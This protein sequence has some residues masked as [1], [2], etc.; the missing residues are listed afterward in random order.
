MKA[1]PNNPQ[2]PPVKHHPDHAQLFGMLMATLL[3]LTIMFGIRYFHSQPSY[4][5]IGYAAP[6]EQQEDF[7][8]N[9]IPASNYYEDVRK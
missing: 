8:N 6:V 9:I 1:F 4:S 7:K 2:H 3:W 5:E